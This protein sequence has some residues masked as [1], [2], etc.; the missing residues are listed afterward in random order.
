MF[1]SSKFKH[2]PKRLN[3][4]YKYNVKEHSNK[5]ISLTLLAYL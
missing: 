4:E 3:F 2:E 5:Y 1:I